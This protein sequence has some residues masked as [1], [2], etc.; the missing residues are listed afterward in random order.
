MTGETIAVLEGNRNHA[1]FIL[2]A[3]ARTGRRVVWT[4]CAWEALESGATLVVASQAAIGGADAMLQFIA[5]ALMRGQHTIAV[6][7][8]RPSTAG[9][10][11]VSLGAVAVVPGW[12]KGEVLARAV[13]EYYARAHELASKGD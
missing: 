8:D 13:D 3:I 1:E 12:W 2:R 9:A 7:S 4:K 6:T 10:D 11:A 5:G